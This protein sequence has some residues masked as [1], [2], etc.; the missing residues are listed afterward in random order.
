MSNVARVCCESD[1]IIASLYSDATLQRQ[2]VVCLQLG[3]S[4]MQ[5]RSAVSTA[6]GLAVV[7]ADLAGLISRNLRL[8][9]HSIK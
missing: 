1:D 4:G 5:W 8:T 3:S 2:V 9:R 7:V 6:A